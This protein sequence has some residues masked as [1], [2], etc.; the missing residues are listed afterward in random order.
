M[1]PDLFAKQSL[2]F[3]YIVINSVIRQKYTTKKLRTKNP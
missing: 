3:R 1:Q 2:P